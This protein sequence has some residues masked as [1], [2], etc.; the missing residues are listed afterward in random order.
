VSPIFGWHEEEFVASY[1]DENW[2]D[3]GRTSLERA[4]QASVPFVRLA[5]ER[6]HGWDAMKSRELKVA[7]GVT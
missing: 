1:A 5:I 6:P 3:S 4:I 7:E 2:V